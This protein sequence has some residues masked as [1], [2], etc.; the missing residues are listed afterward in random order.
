MNKRLTPIAETGWPTKG[1]VNGK[2]IPSV[3]NQKI[4]ISAIIKAKPNTILFTAF[5]DDWKEDTDATKGTE[6]HWGI[7]E[8]Q[9]IAATY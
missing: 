8:I 9:G 6:K 3:E 5:D 4:A 2:A 7:T 1:G